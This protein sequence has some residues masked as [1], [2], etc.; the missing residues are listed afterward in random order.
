VLNLKLTSARKRERIQDAG[1]T[2][3]SMMMALGTLNM[4]GTVT[5]ESGMANDEITL[6]RLKNKFQLKASM[7]T[8]SQLNAVEA[9]QKKRGDD[10]PSAKT[11][12][13]REEYQSSRW[14]SWQMQH[15]QG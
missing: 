8:M 10:I 7:E 13:S 1:G 15:I 2:G 3:G 14:Q 6:E 5:N 12:R 9:E 11:A 4:L